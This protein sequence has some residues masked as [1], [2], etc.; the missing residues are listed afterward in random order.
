[1][2]SQKL[3][4]D[5]AHAMAFDLLATVRN[6]LREEEWQ[7]AFEEF[8]AIAKAGLKRYDRQASRMRRLGGAAG[9]IDREGG[10]PAAD[11]S[12]PDPSQPD[13]SVEIPRA[14]RS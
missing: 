6:C 14:A 3:I 12:R 11:G 9:R 1:M 2:K 8:C 13:A 10:V 5:R 7:D 4:H